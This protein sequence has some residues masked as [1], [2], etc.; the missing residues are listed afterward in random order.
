MFF[1]VIKTKTEIAALLDFLDWLEKINTK[2]GIIFV[3]HDKL[4]FTPY[5]VIEAMKKYRLMDRFQSMVKS[6]VNGYD[7]SSEKAGENG[8]RY[9]TLSQNYKIQMQKLGMETTD[10]NEF[11]GDATVRSK[12]SY[13]IC[14]LMAH[15]GE[16]KDVDEEAMAAIVNDFIRPNAR[17]MNGEMDEI[18]EQEECIKRQ[19]TLRD[20]F[21]GHF[22][23]SRY[24]RWEKEK[25][26][27]NLCLTFSFSLLFHHSRRAVTFRRLLADAKHDMDTLKQ[28]WEEGKRDGIAEHIKKL[29]E[30]KEEEQV[31][32]IEILDSYY[33]P[34]KKAV[35]PV[36][37]RR[38]N[39]N[40]GDRHERN[41]RNDRNDRNGNDRN[42]NMRLRRR[43]APRGRSMNKENQGPRSD[44]RRKSTDK[45]YN[46][47]PSHNNNNM[48]DQK[49]AGRK[50]HQHMD[51]QNQV[52][53]QVAAN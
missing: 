24:H 39:T 3:Y 26:A 40:N 32:L 8:I 21:R 48:M 28:L 27:C 5:M 44:S 11:E 16:K 37:P 33:D 41:D 25:P 12:L 43:R 7:L 23:T 15:G 4:K 6:F 45:R 42:G 1:Q 19:S 50:E 46:N 34:E 52:H 10:V 36:V 20:I 17:P 35:K 13:D 51:N 47:T 53:Q 29:D 18:A 14:M 22:Q 9:L 49:G 38:E 2:D 31:E 30:L